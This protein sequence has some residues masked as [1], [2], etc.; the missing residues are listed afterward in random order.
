MIRVRIK[1][2]FDGKI[3]S[4][5]D[6]I[7][8]ECVSKGLSLRIIYRN[9]FM[10]LSPEELMDKSFQVTRNSFNSKFKNQK[11]QLVDFYW[12]PAD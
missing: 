9:H 1:K 4:I 8:R 6:Y 5:R 2:L 11:Y 10:D 12:Q 3:A 7:V